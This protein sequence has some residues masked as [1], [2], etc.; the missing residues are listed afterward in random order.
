MRRVLIILLVLLLVI[1]LVVF[2]FYAGKFVD[3]QR[4][5]VA[6]MDVSAVS[7]EAKDLHNSLRIADLHSD[8]LLWDRNPLDR[9]SHGHVDIPRLIDGNVT[10][11]VFD[12]VI[13]TPKG[14]NY[15]SNTGDSDNIT[16]LAMANR[17][18]WR[19]WFSLLERARYQAAILD[20]AA[21]QSE[22]TLK[23][24]HSQAELQAYL[25][26]RAANPRQV[27]GVLS[28]EGLHALEGKG[29]NLDRL[30]EAG[31]RI[32]GMTHFFDNEVGGSSSGVAK[33]GLTPLGRQVVKAIEAKG[34]IVDLAHASPKLVEEVLAMSTKP[35]L[36][37]HTGVQGVHDTPRNLSDAQI[38]AISAKKG[39]IGIGF[40]EGAVAMASI[41]DIVASIRHVVAI[42]GIDCV[43]LG[44]DFDGSTHC[45]FDSEHLILL[46]DGLLRGGFSETEIRKIMGE[47]QLRFLLENLPKE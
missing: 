17:W 4:N 24:I 37:T 15:E 7:P 20:K 8:N 1:G 28:I 16:Y 31:Y 19:T 35:I 40:W 46:T 42:G 22:G 47:N 10:L 33:G 32:F 9:L 30:W 39:L 25:T 21:T 5:T 45:A 3:Q 27:A 41:D 44:S 36:V 6:P 13:K 43:A 26:D 34:G 2:F 23:I 14:L 18:P 38:Q 11:Q 12:A 29:E